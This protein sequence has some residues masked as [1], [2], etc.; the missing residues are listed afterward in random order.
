MSH[1]HYVPAAYLQNFAIPQDRYVGKMYGFNLETG[2]SF[3]SNPHGL[4]KER[5]FYLVTQKL[6]R[7]PRAFEK[8]F[9]RLEGDVTQVLKDAIATKTVPAG[10]PFFI[11]MAFV[12]SQA[13]RTPSYRQWLNSDFVI[14]SKEILT[15]PDGA[16]GQAFQRFAK[17]NEGKDTSKWTKEHF[18]KQS[19]LDIGALTHNIDWVMNHVNLMIPVVM[20]LIVQRRWQ[21]AFSE[22]SSIP[23]V[24]GDAPVCLMPTNLESDGIGFASENSLLFL[25]LDA[26]TVLMGAY[27][28]LGSFTTLSDECVA[29][30]NSCSYHSASRFAYGTTP[31]FRLYD[32]TVI[33]DWQ[34]FI[35]RCP[36]GTP[37]N[38]T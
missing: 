34:N 28:E 29:A 33:V 16:E 38:S 10:E 11:L 19:E 6:H 17:D 22:P 9:A 37:G 4:G 36:R 13:L 31:D 27:F 12:A 14:L 7:D 3:P 20:Q 23:L 15:N 2:K 25:P 30:F 35:K 1:D 24:C 5:F 18:R 8:A 26:H 21:I 32:G